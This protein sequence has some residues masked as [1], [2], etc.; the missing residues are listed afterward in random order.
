MSKITLRFN[1]KIPSRFKKSGPH[2][3]PLMDDFAVYHFN[4]PAWV[5]ETMQT[6]SR[7]G[8]FESFVILSYSPVIPLGYTTNLDAEIAR[9]DRE[10]NGGS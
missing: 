9:I 6:Q 3:S 10:E 2:A 4:G 1:R 8:Q 7:A 5:D